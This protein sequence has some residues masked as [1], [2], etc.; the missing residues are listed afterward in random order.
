[1]PIQASAGLTVQIPAAP[2]FSVAWTIRAD[3]YDRASASVG[4]GKTGTLELQPGKAAEILLLVITSSDYTGNVTFNFGGTPWA[5]TEPQIVAGPG[6]MNA[7]T[8]T[9]NPNTVVFDNSAGAADVTIDVLVV[10][11]AVTIA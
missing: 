1:M 5:I 10:R 4:K 3:A 9:G 6:L 2:T 8:H 11:M 7:I